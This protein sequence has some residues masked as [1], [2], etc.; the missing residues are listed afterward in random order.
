MGPVRDPSHLP[1]TYSSATNLTKNEKSDGLGR[2]ESQFQIAMFRTLN[3]LV[4]RKS[5]KQKKKKKK[6][7]KSGSVVSQGGSADVVGTATGAAPVKFQSVQVTLIR[8][9][10]LNNGDANVHP[11]CVVE[12][13]Q[14]QVTTQS[15]SGANARWNALFK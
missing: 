13:D 5:D 8:A 12:Y 10:A 11:V 2:E 3:K 14:Q 4:K 6:K 1:H 7:T 15:A 9:Q